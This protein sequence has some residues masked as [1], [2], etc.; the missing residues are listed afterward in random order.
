M[1]HSEPSVWIPP[2]TE[3]FPY[4][5]PILSLQTQRIIGYEALGRHVAG[6]SVRSLGPFFQ[7]TGLSDGQLLRVDR[8]IR[9]RAIAAMAQSGGEER[10]FLNLKPSWIY[11]KASRVSELPTLEMAQRQGLPASRIVVEITEEP[12]AGDLEELSKMIGL[13]RE[14]GCTIAIDDIGSGH[15]NYDRIASLQPHILKID[16][17]LMKKGVVHEGYHAL[18]N[19][20]SIL[21]SQ[22]GASLLVEGVETKEDLYYAL[23]VGARYVQGFLFSPAKAGLQSPDAYE[24][25]LRESIALFTRS[26]LERHRGLYAATDGLRAL[27]REKPGFD[28]A[29]DADELLQ[30]LAGHVG[31]N[32][33]RMYICREEGFQISSNYT[34]AADGTWSRDTTYEGSNWIWRPYFIPT[35]LRMK[36]GRQGCLSEPYTDLETSRQVHTYSEPLGDTH[37]VFFDLEI[38]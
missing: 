30:T 5:Q 3:T 23:K 4:F 8:T 37:Y 35:V 28:T 26:E 7:Q 1:S 32:V 6:G 9:E 31:N 13:Y 38:E 22:M 16:L 19:S 20:Y 27:L 34:R 36:H 33:V 11:R 10:L 18:L 2:A 14:A 21:A 25:L 15:S 29:G 24:R 12:F 17:K